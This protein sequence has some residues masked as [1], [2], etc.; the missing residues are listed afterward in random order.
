MEEVGRKED[1]PREAHST[2]FV[3]GASFQAS[4]P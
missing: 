2:G 3:P 4:L 1:K